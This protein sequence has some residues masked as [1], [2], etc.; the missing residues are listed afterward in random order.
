MSIHPTPSGK[1]RVRFYEAGVTNPRGCTFSTKD[2]ALDFEARLRL[3]K[4]GGTQVRKASTQTL[5]AFGAEYRDKLVALRRAVP[6]D[7]QGPGEPMEPSRDPAHWESAALATLAHE[8]EILQ[9]FKADL[10]AEGVGDGAIRK[11]LAILSAVLG[12]AV[13]WNRIPSNPVSGVRKPPAKRKRAIEPIAP[14][15]VERLRGEIYHG[16]LL[17]VLMGYAGLRPGEALALTKADIGKRSVSIT[18]AVSLGEVGATKTKVDRVVPLLAPL[19]E[20]LAHIPDGLVVPRSD[21]EVWRDHDWRNWRKREWRPACERV[22]ISGVRPYDL[23]HGLRVAHARRG[24][25]SDRGRLDD[26]PRGPSPVLDLRARDR[27]AAWS[28]PDVSRGSHRH[29][30]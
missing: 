30:A 18:K 7:A 27:R 25:E 1:F 4:R 21:G 2:E 29:R 28:G 23:R 11:T 16:R 20:D 3:A 9:A 17:V 22:G 26:G 13:Q 24:Q 8:P 19:A 6:S 12:V 14:Q 15:Q 10:V 5:E